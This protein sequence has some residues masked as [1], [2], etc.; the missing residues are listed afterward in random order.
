MLHY[1][2]VRMNNWERSI[3][4]VFFEYD[5][6]LYLNILLRKQLIRLLC[7][8]IQIRDLLKSRVESP[9]FLEK[10]GSLY[11]VNSGNFLS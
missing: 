6:S 1:L 11:Q 2:G 7:H 9:E 4:A 10:I 5:F 3:A 8:A